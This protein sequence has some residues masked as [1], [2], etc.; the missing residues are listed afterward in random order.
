[1]FSII[2][3]IFYLFTEIEP[4]QKMTVKKLRFRIV[5]Y[6]KGDVS[7]YETLVKTWF[8]WVSFSVFYKT[9]I[10]HVLYDP[11]D[12]KALAYERIDQYCSVKG[13]KKKDIEIV[14]VSKKENFFCCNI[15]KKFAD[16]NW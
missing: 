1:M 8:G 16:Y 6:P 9:D 4:V 11:F 5:S 7:C 15:F 13:Y 14:E 10:V 12:H 2:I 3:L